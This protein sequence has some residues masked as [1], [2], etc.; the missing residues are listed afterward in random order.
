MEN[1]F[2]LDLQID[3]TSGGITTKGTDTF[4]PRTEDCSSAFPSAI[5]PPPSMNTRCGYTHE[6]CP[7]PE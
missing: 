3:R 5:C 1:I 4:R 2:D 7:L 6:T